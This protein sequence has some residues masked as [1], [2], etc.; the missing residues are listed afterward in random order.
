MS[1]RKNIILNGIANI[2]SRTVRIAD[3]LLLI[4]FF[5]TEWGAAYYGEWLTLTTIPSILAF[6]DLG[7]GS[8]A[9]NSFVLT[10]SSGNHQRAADIYKTGLKVITYAVLLCI[11]ISI[12]VMLIALHTGLLSKSLISPEDAVWSFVFLTTS[13]ITGFYNQLY[14]AMFNCKHRAATATNYLTVEGFVRIGVGIAVLTMGYGVVVFAL[15]NLVVAVVFNVVYAILGLHILGP[16]PKG[17][18]DKTIAKSIFSKGF[19]YMASPIWQSMYFQ[20]TTFIVRIVLGAETVAVF[21]TVRT[22]CRSV[23]Q[24]YSVVNHSIFPEMQIAYGSGNVDKCRK[25]FIYSIK[26]VFFVA[27]VGTLFLFVFGQPLYSWWTQNKLTIP[28]S[29]WYTFMASIVF[30]STWWT[31]GC[32]FRVINKP[33]RFALYGFISAFASTILSYFFA[34]EWGVTGAAIGYTAMDVL[35]AMLVLPSACQC[36]GI[37]L[38]NIIISKHS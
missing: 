30:N 27:C 36:L 24:L 7:F 33:Y 3:Q 18:Y 37:K 2:V 22:L 28:T 16:L 20:G 9:G 21:N 23:N 5:L 13:R 1:I 19:G 31:A 8:A 32:V 4:P 10:Y 12:I 38:K 15:G 35:M 11:T 6:L 14:G 34:R 25:I 29:L 26:T 17:K